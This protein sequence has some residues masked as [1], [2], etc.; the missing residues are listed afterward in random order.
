MVK[1]QK[2]KKF[3]EK[4]SFKDKL[5]VFKLI[6]TDASCKL[7]IVFVGMII[8]ELLVFIFFAMPNG[9][10][11]IE[12]KIEDCKIPLYLIC[13]AGYILVSLILS[14]VLSSK[15]DKPIY[16]L[17]RL[18]VS[19]SEFFR[20]NVLYN[21]LMYFVFICM[22]VLTMLIMFAI[23]NANKGFVGPQDNMMA[24]YR[25]SLFHSFLP[26][27]DIFFMIRNALAALYLGILAALHA[28][29]QREGGSAIQFYI[30]VVLFGLT[31]IVNSM[32][33]YSSITIRARDVIVIFVVSIMAWLGWV[34]GTSHRKEQWE[35][36]AF[37][38]S[39]KEFRNEE[40]S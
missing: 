34:S 1:E 9:K 2:V 5:S 19:E 20:I 37:E 23:F 4:S 30:A 32:A 21:T 3:K 35:T 25:T 8:A 12:L 36:D 26:L 38:A 10:P 24:I 11:Y 27:G 18:R 16:T 40:E 14:N 31:F 17:Q 22:Q 15:T 6:S 33:N 39:I 13:A 28:Q 7:L 29:R